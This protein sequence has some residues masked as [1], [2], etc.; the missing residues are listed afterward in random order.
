M[1]TNGE[2][3]NAG[4]G[5]ENP[6][7]IASPHGEAGKSTGNH[8]SPQGDAKIGEQSHPPARGRDCA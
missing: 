1:K 5:R 7:E 8:A 3:P 6:P 4:G 2:S